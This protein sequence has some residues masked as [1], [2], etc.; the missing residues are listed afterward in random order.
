ML[1]VGTD[2]VFD[3]DKGEP[4]EEG[5]RTNPMNAYGRSKLAGEIG[6]LQANPE[7]VIVRT[8]WLYGPSGTSFPRSIIRTWLEGTPLRVAVDQVGTPTYTGAFARVLRDVMTADLPGGVYHG[9]GPEVLSRRE[10]ARQ[11]LE[12]FR[13]V[14][15]IEREIEIG[16]AKA[17]DFPMP[18]LRPAY[19]ALSSK[20]LVEHGIAPMPPASESLR[21]FCRRMGPNP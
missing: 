8:S 2:Y 1:H 13:E 19:S 6:V 10:W 18:A 7:A 17:A 16:E 11:S 12:A 21:E 9:A 4:Y 15:G 5:D 3:G 14:H 20:K